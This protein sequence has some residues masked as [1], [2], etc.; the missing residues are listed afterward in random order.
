MT[1]KTFR[2]NYVYRNYC[3][4][5]WLKDILGIKT[6]SNYIMFLFNPIKHLI[7]IN[8]SETF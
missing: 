8:L 6:L 5:L 1:H 2:N 4:D 7:K 3:Y